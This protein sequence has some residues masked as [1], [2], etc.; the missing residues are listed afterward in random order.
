MSPEA[1]SRLRQIAREILPRQGVSLAYLFGSHARNR[2][3][4]LSDIDIAVVTEG[5]LPP[6]RRLALELA[7]EPDLASAAPGDYDVRVINHAPLRVAGTVVREGLL[8]YARDESRRVGYESTVRVRYFDLLPVIRF[9]RDAY[10]RAQ[11]EATGS[12][13]SS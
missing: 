8:L 5:I 7:L 2:P 10:L 1:L 11:R 13:R 4:P 12:R 6:R 3:T 9:H